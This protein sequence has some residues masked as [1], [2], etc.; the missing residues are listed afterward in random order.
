[1]S[2]LSADLEAQRKVGHLVDYYVVDND[3]LYKGAMLCADDT[4]GYV[5]P[6]TDAASKNFAGVA[7]EKVDNTATGHSAGGKEIR[8]YK[9]GSFLFAKASAARGDTGKAAYVL[10]DQTVA[11][12]STNGVLAGYIVEVP[13]SSHVQVRIDRAVQ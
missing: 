5:E 4:T 9:T 8:V 7:A 12:T 10:D 3:I 13:D 6:A 2:A 1:M 11:L